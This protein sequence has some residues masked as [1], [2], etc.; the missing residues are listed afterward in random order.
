MMEPPVV[1]SSM[2]HSNRELRLHYGIQNRIPDA[3]ASHDRGEPTGTYPGHSTMRSS[4][5]LYET[6]N[7]SSLKRT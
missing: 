3:A 2:P 1:G 4:V 6:F 7:E 5:L